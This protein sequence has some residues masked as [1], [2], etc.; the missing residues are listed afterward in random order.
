MRVENTG[1]VQEREEE[2]SKGQDTVKKTRAK[3]KRCRRRGQHTREERPPSFSVQMRARLTSETEARVEFVPTNIL[4][5]LLESVFLIVDA[6]VV[7]ARSGHL[8][9]LLS[10]QQ[11]LDRRH[12]HAFRHCCHQ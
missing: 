3:R 7:R 9:L 6:S 12:S 5:A 11:S 2:W 10:G 1:G 8:F 4:R